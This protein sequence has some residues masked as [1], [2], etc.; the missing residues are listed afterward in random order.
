MSGVVRLTD[1]NFDREVLSAQVPVLVE[2]WASWCP[3]CKMMEPVVLQI[4][5]E[6]HGRLKVGKLNVDQDPR[7]AG[8]FGIVGVPTFG[9]FQGGE[10]L[11]RCVGAQ[12]KNQ[13]LSMTEGHMEGWCLQPDGNVQQT[14]DRVENWAG[15]GDAAPRVP[16]P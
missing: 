10:L 13:L 12:S 14:A 1:S 3:P 2:F 4:A 7:S 11:A 6:Y 8:R 15:R 16:V 9:L 5:I